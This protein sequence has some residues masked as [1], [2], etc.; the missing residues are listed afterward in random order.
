LAAVRALSGELLLAAWDSGAAEHDLERAVTLLCLG[1]PERT[2]HEIYELPIP[3][4]DL[5]L[6]RLREAS[7]GRALSGFSVCAQCAARL[8]FT[9][10]VRAMLAS[11]ES[12]ISIKPMVW[13]E[14]GKQM[15]LRPTNTLDLLSSLEIVDAG[16][17]QKFVLARCL[18]LAE[19]PPTIFAETDMAMAQEKFDQLHEPT[20]IRCAT[21]CPECSARGTLDLDIASF[22][23]LEVRAAAARLLG[24]IHALASAYGWT[25]RAILRMAP[26]RR[27]VYLEM[28]SA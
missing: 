24:E 1:F 19:A 3:E 4:R 21:E 12:G 23:W 18:G 7:F 11:L 16:E 8:V 15:R 14:N 22:L 28:L 9:L 17:A 2:R 6:L 27:S 13:T 20:E 5:L 26:R 25:E 10:P